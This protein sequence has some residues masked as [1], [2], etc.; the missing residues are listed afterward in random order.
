MFLPTPGPIPYRP[1]SFTRQRRFSLYLYQLLPPHI[2]RVRSD[3]LPG[4]LPRLPASTTRLRFPPLLVIPRSSSC[5]PVSSFPR[6]VTPPFPP[7]TCDIRSLSAPG[8]SYPGVPYSLYLPPPS[9][10][11]LLPPVVLDRRPSPLPV[12][13]GVAVFFFPPSHVHPH[14]P[15][16]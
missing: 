2:S 16:L 3:R 12:P 4:Q 8:F 14:R 5:E 9:A 13:G 11:P 7:S 15:P 1:Q 10:H 6:P